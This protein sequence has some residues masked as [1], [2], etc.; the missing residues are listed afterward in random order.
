[1]GAAGRLLCTRGQMPNGHAGRAA[2]AVPAAHWPG[3]GR[4]R[5]EAGRALWRVRP[6][7]VALGGAGRGCATGRGWAAKTATRA[8]VDTHR[9]L[10]HHSCWP[11]A[12][13]P[14]ARG[15]GWGGARLRHWSWLGCPRARGRDVGA[16]GTGGPS[17]DG[18]GARARWCLA[19]AGRPACVCLSVCVRLRVSV[20][21]GVCR[22]AWACVC[23]AGRGLT[24]VATVAVGGGADGRGVAAG[25]GV[26]RRG[27]DDCEPAS[28]GGESMA[29][30]HEAKKENSVPSCVVQDHYW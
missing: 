1:M 15:F 7:R 23:V 3:G 6:R 13:V 24:H 14:E 9:C 30:N 17:A 27:V 29:R 20:R 25:E 18:P 26:L 4:V 16:A 21:A 2:R 8:R 11:P 22:C 28:R 10:A 19:S 12:S 5:A